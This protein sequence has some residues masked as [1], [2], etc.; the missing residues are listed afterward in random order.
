M[1]AEILPSQSLGDGISQS[2]PW[3]LCFKRMSFVWVLEEATPGL[4]EK[5][6]HLKSIEEGLVK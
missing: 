4:E 1:E 6:K 5:H 3:S 2:H